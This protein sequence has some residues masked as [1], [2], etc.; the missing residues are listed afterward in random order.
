MPAY[1]R[2]KLA[3]LPAIKLVIF[4]QGCRAKLQG[5]A[6]R[7]GYRARLQGKDAG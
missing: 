2:K 3:I 7:Q 4:L 5:R 6:A 1:S